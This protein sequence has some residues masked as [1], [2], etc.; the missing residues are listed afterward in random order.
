MQSLQYGKKNGEDRTRGQ[1]QY[2]G[3]TKKTKGKQREPGETPAG[4][5]SDCGSVGH[6]EGVLPAED[7][8][9]EPTSEN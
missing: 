2:R 1:S 8:T 6:C 4:Q 9:L 7:T 3:E 5:W